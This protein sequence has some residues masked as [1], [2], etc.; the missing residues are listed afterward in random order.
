[1]GTLPEF[2]L[3][4]ASVPSGTSADAVCAAVRRAFADDATEYLVDLQVAVYGRV[5]RISGVDVAAGADALFAPLARLLLE[6]EADVVDIDLHVITL[7]L[8]A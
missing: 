6:L 4:P 2:H 3:A 8:R 5:V 1:M 7:A